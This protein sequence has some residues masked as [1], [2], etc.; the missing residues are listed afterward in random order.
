MLELLA[1]IFIHDKENVS[2]GSV[3]RAYGS[4]CSYMGIGL[5]ILLFGFKMLAGVMSGSIAVIADSVNNLSDAGSSLITLIGFK[6]SGQKPDPEHPYGHGRMEYITGLL[7][8]VVI[9]LMGFE[10]GKTSFEKIITPQ[11]TVFSLTVFI[12]L[13]VSVAV[14]LYMFS[15]NRAVAKKIKSSSVNAA[16]KDSLSDSAATAVVLI[17]MV[18]GHFSDWNIDGWCGIAVALFIFAAGIRSAKDTISPLLGEPPEPDFVKSIEDIVKSYEEIA[19][20]H[21]LAV[22]N[23]GPGRTMISL[24]AEIPADGDLLSL[25]DTIDN[26][27]RKL[28]DSLGCVAVIHM[29]PIVTNDEATCELKEKIVKAI[30]TIDDRLTIH[31]FRMVV[32]PTHTNVIFDI[33]VPLDI[34]LSEREIKSKAQTLVEICGENLFAVIT[35]DKALI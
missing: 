7:V 20:I 19:G 16:A 11:K 3:R 9:L 26:L 35:V 29:D 23:Y 18:V 25:H 30:K 28:N 15:Y 24:H 17:S 1:N 27:E 13:L 4:L 32:G 6:L 5:N 34:K 2:S 8:S 12:I 21:D 31:D 10:L 22:H 33:T 14:K